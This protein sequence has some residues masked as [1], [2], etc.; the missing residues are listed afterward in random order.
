MSPYAVV[1]A[2]RARAQLKSLETWWRDNRP[3]APDLVA[4]EFR[5]AVSK[6]STFP[7][8]G[9]RYPLYPSADVRRVLMPKTRNH[10]YYVVEGQEVRALAVWGAVKGS[11]PRL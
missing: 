3:D 1:V 2:P 11:G 10:V 6:L 7:L 4:A 8:A 5:A 9:R